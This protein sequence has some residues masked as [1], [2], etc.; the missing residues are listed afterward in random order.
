[1][2]SSFVPEIY[3]DETISCR[4]FANLKCRSPN[5]QS[6]MRFFFSIFRFSRFRHHHPVCICDCIIT[7]FIKHI[8]Q[9]QQ[10]KK[11]DIFTDHFADNYKLFPFSV[12][13]FFF[14]Y[15]IIFKRFVCFTIFF[16]FASMLLRQSI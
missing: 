7:H 6:Q 8:E 5:K 3:G 9:Q 12:A 14:F 10:Q 1:M 15:F 2:Y 13:I 16:P 11:L 4:Q